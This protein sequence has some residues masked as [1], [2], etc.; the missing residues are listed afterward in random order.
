MH[1]HVDT[2]LNNPVTLT[3]DGLTSGSMQ[4]EVL[5]YVYQILC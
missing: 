3:F 4:A 2:T 1:T 5:L